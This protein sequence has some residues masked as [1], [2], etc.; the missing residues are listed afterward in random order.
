MTARRYQVGR[1]FIMRMAG[2][3]VET[4]IAL[5]SPSLA[6]AVDAHAGGEPLERLYRDELER[7]RRALYATATSERFRHMLLL[8][9]PSLLA[10]TPEDAEP[11]ALDSDTRRRERAWVTYLQRVA[12]KNDTISFFGPTA[13]GVV[14]PAQDETFGLELEPEVD[15]AERC[16]MIE[17]WVVNALV[18]AI[19]GD[20]E[21]Q[22]HLE[23]LWPEDLEVDTLT[24]D[25]AERRLLER[26]RAGIRRADIADTA[27]LDGL[28]A[29]GLLVRRLRVP[30]VSTP[31][32]ALR[33]LVRRWPLSPA[34]TRWLA[35]LDAL[36][37]ARLSFEREPTLEQR[38][39][40]LARIQDVLVAVGLS[41]TND[42][43]AIY[44][45]RLPVNEDCRR[46]T[47]R[48]RLG[49]KYIDAVTVE[50]AP[51]YETWRDIAGLYATRLHDRLAAIANPARTLSFARLM[52]ACRERRFPFEAFGGIGLTPE[53]DR[54]LQAAWQDQL[55]DRMGQREVV[56]TADDLAFVR[57]RF[58]F[59]RMK[60]CD[61]P[62]PD[63]QIAAPGTMVLGEVHPDTSMWTQCVFMWCPDVPELVAEY[64]RFH[65]ARSVLFSRHLEDNA[66]HS[67]AFRHEVTDG[68]TLIGGPGGGRQPS[69]RGADAS[70]ELTDDDAVVR[71]R[72][73]RLL[74]SLVHTWATAINTHHC[75]L[76][77]TGD[78]APRLRVGNIVVQREIWMLDVDEHVRDACKKPGL[79]VTV[80]LRAW[81]R[82]HG[83]PEQVVVHPWLP[84]R[85]V[86]HKDTKPFFVDFRS[87]LQLDVL[88]SFIRKYRKLRVTEAL[89]RLED[90]WLGDAHGH[91]SFELRAP[92]YPVEYGR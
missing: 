66:I 12:T 26:A 67:Q 3:P 4:M 76:V 47:R 55:G 42:S 36:E 62:A 20:A 78:H 81:R 1:Q 38:R 57:Q 54:E 28:V 31:F 64:N 59:R 53:V 90:C 33:A 14:D 80:A 6:D 5:T 44:A 10:V 56:L 18:A 16:V 70:V 83:L 45:S 37:A 91:Y 35:H 9:S 7:T 71:D 51:W 40:A 68:W 72:D 21:A 43:R 24:L 15:V 88:A 19:E 58:A 49:S 82:A 65:P 87:P 13:W 32:D 84:V 50:L 77:G 74:G 29:R 39:V 73:G 69:V 11:P 27:V 61:V 46:A 48:M 63:L 34:R 92:A 85:L 86:Q 22:V 75:V 8:S 60:S 52:A 23:I 2:F 25:P 89:P 41:P 17:R 30:L 79:G